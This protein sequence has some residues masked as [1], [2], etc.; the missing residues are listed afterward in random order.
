MQSIDKHRL[1]KFRDI[2]K[3]NFILHL[4]ETEFRYNVKIKSIQFHNLEVK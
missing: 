2:S 1:S 4:K 3:N